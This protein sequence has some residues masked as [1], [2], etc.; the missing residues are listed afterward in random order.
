M[1]F[2]ERRLPSETPKGMPIKCAVAI[3]RNYLLCFA[4][5][6]IAY[7]STVS[8]IVSH[9]EEY[10]YRYLTSERQ[11]FTIMNIIFTLQE[12]H[13][14]QTDCIRYIDWERIL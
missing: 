1:V 2:T 13:S 14:R 3:Y 8:S 12:L 11:E 4:R 9:V 10:F 7:Q 5:R 6:Y